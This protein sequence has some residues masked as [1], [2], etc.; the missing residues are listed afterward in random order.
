MATRWSRYRSYSFPGDTAAVQ[1]GD[2]GGCCRREDLQHRRKG[3]TGDFPHLG[4]CHG[5]NRRYPS[6][7]GVGDDAWG[8]ASWSH[9][10]LLR[11]QAGGDLLCRLYLLQ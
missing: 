6:S 5:V 8:G 7:L 11:L 4:Y 3:I 2:Q 1:K 9:A 10:N